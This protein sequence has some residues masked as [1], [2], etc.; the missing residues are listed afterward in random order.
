LP[1]YVLVKVLVP[2]YFARKDTRTPVLTA[3][4]SL[5]LNIAL[6]FLL[7]PHFGIAGLAMAGSL[8]AWSNTLMLYA[9]LHRRGQYRLNALVAGRIARIALAAA[10]MGGALWF[11]LPWFGGSF[12]GGELERLISVVTLVG[13]GA[14]TF[15]GSAW[16]LGV[17]NSDTIG[18]LR[19][20][21][22]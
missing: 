5:L 11:M 4:G 10:I 20:R 17:V 2:N 16:A 9:I 7:I 12:T 3:A 18:Q 1:A 15:F 14:M 6:N 19:R 8:A 21:K 13:V 22:A